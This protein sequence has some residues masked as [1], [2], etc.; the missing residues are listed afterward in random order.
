MLYSYIYSVIQYKKIEE[1]IYLSHTDVIYFLNETAHKSGLEIKNI[2]SEPKIKNIQIGLEIMNK[3]G[4]GKKR[5]NI[6]RKEVKS[7]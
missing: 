1:Y 2:Q 7:L 5:I 6:I 4:Y 3:L